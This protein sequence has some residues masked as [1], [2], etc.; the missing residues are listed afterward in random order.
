MHRE[1][2]LSALRRRGRV[3]AA[4]GGVLAVGAAGTMALLSGTAAAATAGTCTDNVNVRAEPRVDAPVVTVCERGT[5][6]QVGEKRNGFVKLENLKGWAAVQY[7]QT[8]G[9]GGAPAA[10]GT[11][12]TTPKP[13]AGNAPKPASTTAR[14]GTTTPK[15]TPPAAPAQPGR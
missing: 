9:A 11:P 14:T 15:T 2:V 12:K 3:T 13:T 1:T 10:T 5:T 8:T 6:V 7:V 4:V